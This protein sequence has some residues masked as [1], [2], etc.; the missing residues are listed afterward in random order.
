MCMVMIQN[1]GVPCLVIIALRK[2]FKYKKETG[3]YS[4]LSIYRQKRFGKRIF[5]LPNQLTP[6]NNFNS[7]RMVSISNVITK[8]IGTGRDSCGKIA[9]KG[10]LQVLAEEAPLTA[11]GKTVPVAEINCQL[12]KPLMKL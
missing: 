2:T 9:S 3:R 1:I 10:N 7:S 6:R 5:I 11:R 4:C 8:L 12:Y